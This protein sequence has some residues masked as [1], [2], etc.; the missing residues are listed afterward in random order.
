[1][2]DRMAPSKNLAPRGPGRDLVPYPPEN[3][4][5]A[6]KALLHAY[7][8]G[9][10]ARRAGP[11]ARSIGMEQRL[12]RKSKGF[13]GVWNKIPAGAPR[14]EVFGRS[15]MEDCPFG[16]SLRLRVILKNLGS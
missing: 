2:S 8:R 5:L 1:M 6:A 9:P 4:R 3:R 11:G 7:G 10:R 13:W 12:G 14:G 16:G 15:H